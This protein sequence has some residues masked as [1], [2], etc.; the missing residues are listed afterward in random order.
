[1]K[2]M[3][4]APKKRRILAPYIEIDIRSESISQTQLFE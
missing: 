2:I 1:M 3:A 4:L